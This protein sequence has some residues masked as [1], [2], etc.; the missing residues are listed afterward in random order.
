M[1]RITTETG[2]RAR[3]VAVAGAKGSPGCT[4][5]AVGLARCLADAGL[6]VLLLDADAEEPG[7]AAALA[8]PAGRAG[9]L[10]RAT[11]LGVDPDALDE[12][13]VQVGTGLRV[14]EVAGQGPF[15]DIGSLPVDGRELA[16]SAREVYQAAVFDLGH[17]WG[18]LQRQLAAAADWLLWVLV[19]DRLGVERADR[20]LGGLAVGRS[21]GLVVNRCSRWSL[22]GAERILV[23]RHHLPLVARLPENRRGARAVSE[24][25]A[26][27]HHQRP[28]RRGLETVARTV[29]PDL[30]GGGSWP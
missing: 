4:F 9:D 16:A 3:V 14:L 19:P 8:L 18:P 15:G 30:E 20:A 22:A 13:S 24:R 12:A 2:P 10:A 21:R 1:R 23:E 27:A 11:T 28:F 25:N 5:V 26:A 29:H 17:S 6:Q 7:V